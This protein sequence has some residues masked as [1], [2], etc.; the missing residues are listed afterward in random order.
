MYSF[1]NDPS[2]SRD[3]SSG[4]T[5]GFLARG[6]DGGGTA[7]EEMTAQSDTARRQSDGVYIT[8]RPRCTASLRVSRATGMM[9]RKHTGRRELTPGPVRSSPAG[10][11]ITDRALGRRAEPQ[12]CSVRRRLLWVMESNE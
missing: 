8:H 3:L 11:A 2:I 5:S 4:A 12:R 9:R 10:G 6:R 7:V 1:Q